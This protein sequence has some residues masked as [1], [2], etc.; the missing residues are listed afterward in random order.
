V[1][2]TDPSGHSACWDDHAN[3]P[4]CKQYT[5]TGYGLVSSNPPPTEEENGIDLATGAVLVLDGGSAVVSGVE[6]GF[7]DVV[8]GAIIAVGCGGAGPGTLGVSCGISAGLALAVDV[9]VSSPLGLGSV[10]N[11]M[12][13]LSTG[14][15]YWNDKD[16][17]W[18]FDEN[19][20]TNYISVGRDTVV[21]ARNTLAGT[22]PESNVDAVVSFSQFKYDLDRLSGGKAGGPILLMDSS[23]WRQDGINELYRQFF[24]GDW[25][26]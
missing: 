19:G 7:S 21:S 25:W 1:N 2:A 4:G 13:Y 16:N 15:T 6:A 20:K 22:L 9:Y 11:G 18:G 24:V 12:G 3:D 10:E 5:P 17:V 26:R 8:G 23:G 14:I